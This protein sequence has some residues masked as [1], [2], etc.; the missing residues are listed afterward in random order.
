M[1]AFATELAGDAER[2]LDLAERAIAVDPGVP[3]AHHA[4]AHALIA[5]GNDEDALARLQEFAPAWRRPAG[6]SSATTRWHLASWHLDQLDPHGAERLFR[7]VVWG[8]DPGMV[9][10]QIDA[11]SLLWRRELAGWEVEDERWDDI[12][13]HAERHVG[14]CFMPFLSAHHAYALARAGR[15]D[16]LD[17]L[18]AGVQ[19]RAEAPDPEAERVWRPV[20][21]SV[22]RACAT[23]GRGDAA[24]ATELLEPVMGK[25]TA[26]GGSDAQNDLFRQ[27]YLS[28]LIASGRTAEARRYWARMTAWKSATSALDDAWLDRI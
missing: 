10:E 11:I 24:R 20:G 12:A 1:W 16:A 17:E 28:G 22:V 18:L 14:E 9:G 7:D 19:R 3:W 15:T 4:M 23:H 13:D 27:A 25:L 6:S 8:V 21:A 26:I 2:A 5:R